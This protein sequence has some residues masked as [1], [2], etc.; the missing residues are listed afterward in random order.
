MSA[1]HTGRHGVHK[2]RRK[3]GRKKRK[4][5]GARARKSKR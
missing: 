3:K 4:R 2:G 5:L 1:N